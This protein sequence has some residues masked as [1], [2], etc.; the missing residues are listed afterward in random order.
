[1]KRKLILAATAL[2]ALFIGFAI[3]ASGKT[4]TVTHTKTVTATTTVSRDVVR[5]KKIVPAD[6][7]KAIGDARQFAQLAAQATRAAATYPPDIAQAARAA[8]A[9]DTA[10]IYAVAAKMSAASNT[11]GRLA[12]TVGAVAE[13]FNT[14]AAGCR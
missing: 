7:R 10:T 13:R 11:I 1:M 5:V 8:A 12:T 9:R 4:K 2:V 3:G 6:C 14:A